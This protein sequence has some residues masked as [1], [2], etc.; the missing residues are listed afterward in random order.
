MLMSKLGRRTKS[1]ERMWRKYKDDSNYNR[2]STTPW[3]VQY[4]VRNSQATVAVTVFVAVGVIGAHFLLSSTHANEMI[5]S[6]SHYGIGLRSIIWRKAKHV[7]AT[8]KKG[9]AQCMAMI[10]IT[11]SGKPYVATPDVTGSYGPI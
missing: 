10:S 3:I 6:K 4:M 5:P 2:T 8:P 7:C 9:H 1:S 11:D